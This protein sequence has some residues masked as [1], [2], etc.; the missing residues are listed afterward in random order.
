MG[1]T[2]K[3][4][5]DIL[6]PLLS[7]YVILSIPLVIYK[8]SAQV[9]EPFHCQLLHLNCNKKKKLNNVENGRK[10]ETVHILTLYSMFYLAA[11][12][13]PKKLTS[14]Q[15]NIPCAYNREVHI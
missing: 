14:Y 8:F 12:H 11:Q 13:F 7:S 5:R 1:A 3:N 15:Q 2:G 6:L 9:L 10:Y 4:M